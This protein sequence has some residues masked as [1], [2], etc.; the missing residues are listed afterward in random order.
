MF[1]GKKR[2]QMVREGAIH[3]LIY[4]SFGLEPWCVI[5]Y[6][7]MVIGYTPEWGVSAGHRRTMRVFMKFCEIFAIVW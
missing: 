4:F 6:R 2:F 3:A 7:F 1:E 5:A